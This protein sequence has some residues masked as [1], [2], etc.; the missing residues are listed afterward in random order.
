MSPLRLQ[1]AAALSFCSFCA[2]TV[3]AAVPPEC[4]PALEALQREESVLLEELAG[5]DAASKRREALRR[6]QPLRL[7]AAKAC[8]A[9]LP[10]TPP[11]SQHSAQPPIATPPVTRPLPVPRANAPLALPPP[12]SP[13]VRSAAP[14]SIVGCDPGGCT[15]SDGSRLQR[16]GAH[17]IGPR[18]L[19]LVQGTQLLCP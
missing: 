16:A 2:T 13:T 11:P 1:L 19:C 14:L 18:G 12:V 4:P 7:R 15:A 17:L 6:L 5:R 10:A 8:L 3:A 9:G